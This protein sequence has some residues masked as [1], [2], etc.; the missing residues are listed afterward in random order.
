S[1]RFMDQMVKHYRHIARMIEYG[2]Q[3]IVEK[4]QPV[5]HARKATAFADR[6]IECI[7]ALRRTEHR[8]IILA[9]TAYH[10]RR[11]RNL[12]HRLEYEFLARAGGALRSRIES[13]D[14]LQRIAEEIEPQRLLS[15]RRI[16]IENAAAHRIF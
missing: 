11:E 4:R 12:A 9:E 15:T 5:L 13:A 3:M 10:V 2:F 1:Q 7:V 6:L 8:H 16:K 14:R